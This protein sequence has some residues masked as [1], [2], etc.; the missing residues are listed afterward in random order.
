MTSGI[1][2]AHSFGEVYAKTAY[3]ET[4]EYSLEYTEKIFTGDET[5]RYRVEVMGK[6]LNLFLNGKQPYEYSEKTDA[7]TEYR[8]PGVPA[9]SVFVGCETYRAFRP[10]KKKRS[11]D[12]TVAFGKKELCRELDKKIPK[13]AEV[14][15]KNITY[16]LSE[17]GK[18]AVSAEYICIENIALQTP[19]DKIENMNYDIDKNNNVQN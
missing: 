5:K 10:E 17:G 12:E 18:V 9:P 16:R 19:I 4:R 11:I 6:S 2:Y 8:I 1:R 3:C 14:T 15:D 7:K 13:T